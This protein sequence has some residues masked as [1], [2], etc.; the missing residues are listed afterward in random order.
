MRH[1]HAFAIT[2]VRYRKDGCRRLTRVS[3]AVA[4]LV[5]VVLLAACEEGETPSASTAD[6]EIVAQETHVRTYRDWSLEE[7]AIDEPP[8]IGD[9]EQLRIFNDRI[10]VYDLASMNIERYTVSGE[11]EAVYG[12]GRGQAPGQ[13]QNIFS[14]WVLGEEAVWIVDSMSRTVSSFAYDGAFVDSFRPEFAPMRVVVLD[15]DRLVLQMFAQP[16]LFA[17][18]D[19][20]GEIR[21]RF[22][23]VTGEGQD[24]HARFFDAHVYPRPGGGFIWA[25]IYAS[26]LF[27]YNKNPELER[28]MELIDDHR[29]PAGSVQEI[30]PQDLE[31][32]QRTMAVSVTDE[33]IFVNTL[34]RGEESTASVLDRYDRASGK[35]LDSIRMPPDGSRYQ[36]Y[37]G[38]IYG[39]VADTTFRAYYVDR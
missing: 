29:W 20:E 6:A 18:V 11:L 26:Y 31:R 38:M 30:P 28:R 34:F 16:E 4:L 33:E 27:F 32:P 9:I 13:F 2:H 5:T 8:I 36:V 14:F 24:I 22:G 10:F 7:V 25:P 21:M 37:D 23:K 19:E 39:G 1:L 17:M 15:R 35:Y 3:V 12:E